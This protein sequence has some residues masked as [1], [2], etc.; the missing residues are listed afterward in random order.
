ME[1]VLAVIVLCIFVGGVGYIIYDDM[2]H[3][4]CF[5]TALIILI[6]AALTIAGVM[7]AID[8]LVRAIP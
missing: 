3:D 6:G 5:S 2:K 7:W 4:G 8:V 1:V